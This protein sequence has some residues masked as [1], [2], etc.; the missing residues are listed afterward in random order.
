MNRVES[1]T[2]QSYHHR[3]QSALI[4][5][6][7]INHAWIGSRSTPPWCRV[8]RRRQLQEAP[9]KWCLGRLALGTA[10]STSF[11]PAGSQI[12]P[13]CCSNDAIKCRREALPYSI[14]SWTPGPAG[15]S[16]PDAHHAQQEGARGVPRLPASLSDPEHSLVVSMSS[17]AH[18]AINSSAWGGRGWLYVRRSMAW[19]DRGGPFGA[20]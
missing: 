7:F 3:F 11:E 12:N 5:F 6:N 1:K 17:K 14:M 10:P 13:C 20:P 19:L 8:P 18:V 4:V 9:Y 2:H 15:P 16:Q